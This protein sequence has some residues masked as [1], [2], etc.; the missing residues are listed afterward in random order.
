MIELTEV[1]SYMVEY[2]CDDCNIGYME[3]TGEGVMKWH[4]E[5]K[6]KCNHCGKV[7]IFQGVTYPHIEHKKI[8]SK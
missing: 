4:T 5:W 1:K 3:S 6:H 7:K 2:R 8:D